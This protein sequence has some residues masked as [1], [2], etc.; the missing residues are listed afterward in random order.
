MEIDKNL[1]LEIID[2]VD[3]LV[4]G[5]FDKISA[6]KWY[7][8]LNKHDIETRLSEYGN[9]LVSPP[10]SFVDKI[11]TYEYNDGSSLA[12]NVPLWTEEEGMSDLTLSLELIHDGT[13][14]RLQ[15]TDLR[16]L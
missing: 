5:D 10:A 16:V 3:A 15:I 9:T 12:L 1:E 11:D 2:L 4:N 14:A 6:K 8:R 13:K 7:G